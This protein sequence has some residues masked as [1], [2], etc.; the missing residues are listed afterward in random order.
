MMEQIP[1]SR[2]TYRR[3]AAMGVLG[4]AASVGALA[5]ATVLITPQETQAMTEYATCQQFQ[6][7]D[8]QKSEQYPS[9]TERALQ[10]ASTYIGLGGLAASVAVIGLAVERL[11]DDRQFHQLIAA[12]PNTAEEM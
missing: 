4:V 11:R 1:K 3:R 6:M 5:E 2:T 9:T 10:T 12:Y 7:T 8:C